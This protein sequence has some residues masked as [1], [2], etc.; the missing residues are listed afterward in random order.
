MVIHHT[1]V[2]TSLE[3]LSA[4]NIVSTKLATRALKELQKCPEHYPGLCIRK[5]KL[6]NAA[7]ASQMCRDSAISQ[8]HTECKAQYWNADDN[9]ESDSL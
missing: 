8:I 9:D 2:C 5:S 6:E 1:S 7:I 3:N 4:H